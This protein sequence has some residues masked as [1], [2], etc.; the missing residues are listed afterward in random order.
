[1]RNSEA[2]VDVSPL[3]GDEIIKRYLNYFQNTAKLK[4]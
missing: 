2:F 3:I 1:M 4:V